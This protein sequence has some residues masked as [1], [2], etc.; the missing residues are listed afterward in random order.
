MNYPSQSQQGQYPVS[1]QQPMMHSQAYQVN[2]MMPKFSAGYPSVYP[3]QTPNQQAQSQSISPTQLLSASPSHLVP[4]QQIPQPLT[5]TPAQL[6]Q[7][8]QGGSFSPMPGLGINIAPIQ[9][10]IPIHIPT[11]PNQPQNSPMRIP[12][13]PAMNPLRYAQMSPQERVL[14]Q[15]QQQPVPDRPPGTPTLHDRGPSLTHER[16]PSQHDRALPDRQPS[17]QPHDRAHS[18]SHIQADRPS[19]SASVRSHHSH[20]PHDP[21]PQLPMMPPPNSRPGTA[22]GSMSTP[23]RMNPNQH[24][25]NLNPNMN[26]NAHMAPTPNLNP[27]MNQAH[28]M[29]TA[30]QLNPASMH[31]SGASIGIPMH[32][33]PTRTGSALGHASPKQSPRLSMGPMGGAPGVG[34][35]VGMGNLAPGSISNS[36]AGGMGASM[37]GNIGATNMANFVGPMNGNMG[38]SIGPQGMSPM[39]GIATMGGMGPMNMNP[40][41]QGNL[42]PGGS[43]MGGAAVALMGPPVLPQGMQRPDREPM[44]QP[45]MREPSAPVSRETVSVVVPLTADA[46]GTLQSLPPSS[47]GPF[48]GLDNPGIAAIAP[49]IPNMPRQGSQPP[50]QQS[51]ARQVAAPHRSPMP[52]MRKI[53]EIPG[54]TR[55]PPVNVPPIPGTTPGQKLPPHIASLNP[56][57]TKISYI[58]Y[59]V[60]PKPSDSA[61]AAS[62]EDKKPSPDELTTDTDKDKDGTTETKQPVKIQDP[63]PALTPFEIT[64]L[65]DVMTRD[66]AYETV[67]RAKQ[68]RMLQELRTAGPGGR[69][70]W[71]DREFAAN[72]GINRRPD[73]FDVRYPRPPRTD[74]SMGARKKG[75][76]RE[77]I[78]VP[79]KL[80]P[81]LADRPEQLVPIR[82]EFDVEHH[83]MR[84]TFVWNLND[85]VISPEMFAQTLVEDY[86]LSST[87]HSVITKSIQEQLSDFKAHI[88]SIDTDWK[89]PA[90]EIPQQEVHGA[91]EQDE[92]DIEIVHHPR[93]PALDDNAP[94]IDMEDDGVIVG[95]GI[96]DEEA[97]QWWESWRKRAKKEMPTRIVPTNRRKKR[98]IIAKIEDGGEAS[99]S[100]GNGKE[101]PRTVDEF[102]VDEQKVH[103]DLRILIKLDIIVGSMKLDDQFEWDL[104]NQDASP[105]QFADVYANEL[106]LGGEF[107]TAIAHCIREQVQVYQKSLFLV[108]HPA[109]GS[110]VQDDD[111]RMSFLP[112]LTSATRAMDQV[113]SFT[114]ILNYLSD[115]D[116]ER[117]EKE[118]EKELTKRRKR[119]TRGRRG[120]A[121]PDREPNR[122]YRTPA[123]GFP[124]L[125]PATLAMAAAASA[126]TSRRAA[127][128][129]ASLTIANMV[130]SENG[131]SIMPL[132]LPPQQLTPQ[133]TLSLGKEKKPKGLFK[134]PDYP[135]EILRPRARVTAP[136]PTTAVESV[137]MLPPSLLENDPPA[138]VV[139]PAPPDTKAIAKKAREIERE[140][141]EKE[142]AD[143]QHANVIN[144]VWHCSNCGCPESIA[145][146]RRKGPLG[147][148]SQCGTCGKFWHRHRRPRPVQYNSDPQYHLS[149]RNEELG[150]TNAKK[151]GRAANSVAA[152]GAETPS[153][154]KSELWIEVPTR[155]PNSATI[156]PSE[157]DR[158]VSPVSTASSVSEA[159][160]A[161]QSLKM[162]G[163]NQSTS[164]AAPPRP[165]T[166]D[167]PRH[168]AMTSSSSPGGELAL[169]ASGPYSMLPAWLSGAIV[170]L[171]AKY[172]DDKFEAILR[173]PSHKAAPEWRV[174][175]LDC[176]G[177]LYNPGPGD[178]LSNYEVHLKN[179]QHRLRVSSRT[180]ATS[181]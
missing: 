14:F 137:S 162:N 61:D 135:R 95:R 176:P 48:M 179:R 76:R 161:Q 35:S 4:Q 139:N 79:R 93:Q 51:P 68:A 31:M 94:R 130:A 140:A 151:R 69:L 71:W 72:L 173:K 30:P 112:S 143:G 158:P 12:F 22:S 113:Q 9:Q 97:V 172:P 77:G 114:P 106:G 98:K 26:I 180:K 63:V 157:D 96:L 150:K 62:D 156:P 132:Q 123:I 181:S 144:G 47:T 2:G 6:L 120:I 32:R 78:R 85:P 23:S 99:G 70:A 89:P 159:P 117:S 7:Q 153:R 15:R 44:M 54:P 109:D 163:A 170:S 60:P 127:A 74:G 45:H 177:K 149:L 80:P 43:M 88:A 25:M 42:G 92:S 128:A 133:V 136:T 84:E 174:K 21:P 105:E 121:L 102:E 56:A 28:Q 124:E 91:E 146:G 3:P 142:F 53:G 110:A 171:Q 65:K 39:Q 154:Q 115:G 52:P 131:T 49:N 86:A 145:I 122:T 59:V 57:V 125:D 107:K 20:P 34:P 103:E 178:S 55:T 46:Y 118:R 119:N 155:P 168:P 87:Y 108:G 81:E 167:S 16:P 27:A 8:Q 169:S 17:Q 126:P 148:K 11:T 73:R 67:Y 10:N 129:A 82:L 38:M 64:T 175:C 24:P 29:G 58:P 5:L 13:Q 40:S 36:L 66:S 37:G 165:S 134:A 166:P 147:D 75:A 141:K 164:T 18:Q 33:P 19:S 152:D 116:I 41:T 111:L 160:L 1:F 100:K 90:I 50:P 138:L 104:E 101:R 83:K